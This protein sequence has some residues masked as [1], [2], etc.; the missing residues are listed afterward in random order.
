MA[1]T[2]VSATDRFTT[3]YA[4]SGIIFV[5]WKDGTSTQGSCS[6]VGRNDIL[7]AGH[8][9]YNPDRGGW[10][11]RFSFYFGADY[12][13]QTDRFDSR[14]WVY[15]LE[16]GSFR[17]SSWAWPESLY[18]DSDNS[19]MRPSES[20][21]DV[22]LIGVSVA[23]GDVTG[24][25]GIDP[26]R[27]YT[28]TARSI[29]YPNNGTGM[30]T[31]T[32]LATRSSYWGIYESSSEVM[33][34]GGSGGPLV[35]SDNYL[36]GVLSSGGSSGDN[37][38]DVGFL[39]NQ[40]YPKLSDNDSLLGGAVDDYAAST[41][42]TGGVSV[43]GST[44]GTIESVGDI[45]WFKV[46]LIAGK[47]YRF[48]L[49]KYAITGAIGDPFLRLYSS[50]GVLLSSDDDS[51]DGL[52]AEISFTASTTG[53]YYIAALQSTSSSA[54]SPTT[55]AYKVSLAEFVGGTLPSYIITPNAATVDEGNIASFTV[56]TMN[57]AAGTSLNYTLSGGISASD[58]IGGLLAGTTTVATSGQ[59]TIS[60]PIAADRTTEGNET[61]TVTVQGKTASITIVDT[62]VTPMVTDFRDVTA[63]QDSSGHVLFTGNASE[64]EIMQQFGW[65]QATGLK[66]FET[67]DHPAGVTLHKFYYPP[68][69]SFYYATDDQ[70]KAVKAAFNGWVYQGATDMKVYTEA[71]L[72]SG[73]APK[74]SVPIY[75]MWVN[76]TGHVYTTDTKLVDTL[77]GQ[78]IN[79][80]LLTANNVA[81]SKG[82]YNGVVFWGDPVGNNTSGSLSST[83]SSSTEYRFVTALQDKEGHFLFTANQ[84]EADIMQQFGW[85]VAAGVKGFESADTASGVT[86]HK[87][88][89]PPTNSFYYA[90]DDQA[91]AVKASFTGWDYQGATDLKVYTNTSYAA[92]KA[93]TGSVP[94]YQMWVNGKGHVYTTDTVLVDQLMG[95]DINTNVLTANNVATANGTYNGVVFWGDPT[96]KT[97]VVPVDTT[98]PTVSSI[99][100]T[101]VDSNNVAK[102]GALVQGNRVKVVLTMSEATAV[103]GTPSF[104]IDVGGST[105]TA[106]Y[107]SGSGS[108]A[109]T[110]YYA[111][112]AGDLDSTG[113][114]T[115]LANALTLPS[116]SSIKDSAGNN[117]TL[118]T[119][120]IATGTNAVSIDAVAPT[121]RSYSPT[122]GATN[123]AIGSNFIFTFSEA[124]KKGTGAILLLD[125]SGS[126]V[127]SFDVLTSTRLTWASNT[128]TIDPTYDLMNERIYKW[129]IPSGAIEDEAGNDY[130]GTNTYT[131]TTVGIDT[132][133]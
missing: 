11:D 28:Q 31:D 104:T 102:S 93:P 37:W 45:D 14:N 90:T 71:Q 89:Y 3:P 38:A 119:A 70:A 122:P 46:T 99:Q 92:G 69:N 56:T 123:V 10:A 62:S 64:A 6:V 101:G 29:G 41:A 130:I 79:T 114:I 1:I 96:T 78:D 50:A 19:T 87:F 133:F 57:V 98:P 72:K 65:K 22:A 53:T 128:L 51:G 60:V 83:T 12:N 20:Q 77:M 15:S 103:I 21:Y 66:A 76:G 109:L 17:W 75:Q 86:L 13:N 26:N 24:W 111:V 129:E 44:S 95:Q 88:Y 63:L 23:I 9:I 107:A 82:T 113:G 27:D 124:I 52:N 131:V 32:F 2:E 25:L 105:K 55:G 115:T 80:D 54:V 58:I 5:T 121:V 91:K 33:G 18:S 118:T 126:V 49:D 110:F 30:M 4:Q 108:N 43:G 117:A 61:L 59:A 100:I 36:I 42:T 127:E 35:T 47:T 40:L 106:Q 116:G 68:T 97:P 16:S 112:E 74:E 94:I 132:S 81:T 73:V 7:T 34:P 67:V 125:A 120:S 39:W 84:T 48:T 85:S 8:V